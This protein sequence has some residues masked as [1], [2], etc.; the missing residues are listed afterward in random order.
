MFSNIIKR[1]LIYLRT[2]LCHI[3]T[4]NFKVMKLIFTIHL[5][6]YSIIQKKFI[7]HLSHSGQWSMCSRR[8]DNLYKVPSFL[9]LPIGG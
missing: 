7:E 4:Q 6:I 5:S 1:I 3:V 2:C 8:S 9:E